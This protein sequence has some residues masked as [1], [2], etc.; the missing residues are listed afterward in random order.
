[1]KNGHPMVLSQKPKEKSSL[2]ISYPLSHCIYHWIDSRLLKVRNI[3]LLQNCIRKPRKTHSRE[4]QVK[5][6]TSIDLRSE[7]INSRESFGHWEGDSVVGKEGKNSILTLVERQTGYAFVLQ[8]DSKTSASTFQSLALL[9]GRLSD[10]F[11]RIFH[12]I[13]FDNGAEFAA[14]EHF[15]SLGPKIYYAHP[16]SAWE[17]GQN[18]QFN[19]MLR[20]FIPKGA[21]MASLTQKDLDR[22][23]AFLNSLPRKSCHY[24]SPDVLFFERLSAIMSS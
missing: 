18:E 4:H 17:R 15:E 11:D 23:A 1:M 19:G 3:D 14:S 13:T 10:C 21:D 16:Y 12:S 8:T 2:R 9:K 24:F 22:S 7:E 6:G 5:L 20:R